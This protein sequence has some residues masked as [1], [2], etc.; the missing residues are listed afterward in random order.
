[1]IVFRC[2]FDTLYLNTCCHNIKLKVLALIGMMN[3]IPVI[4]LYNAYRTLLNSEYALLQ[5]E[6]ILL[7]AGCGEYAK[8]YL[9]GEVKKNYVH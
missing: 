6:L 5:L 4:P 7:V 3:I 1:M 9:L 8:Y 2:L